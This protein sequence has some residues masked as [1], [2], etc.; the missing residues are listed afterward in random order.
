MGGPPAPS[1]GLNGGR[2]GNSLPLFRPSLGQREAL[3]PISLIRGVRGL[4]LSLICKNL[5]DA[6]HSWTLARPG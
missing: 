3:P 1:E 6:L 5:L 4:L 2:E